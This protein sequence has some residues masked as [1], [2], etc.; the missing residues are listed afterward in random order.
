[1]LIKKATLCSNTRVIMRK[2]LAEERY[3]FY[4]VCGSDV[5]S[6]VN[7][8]V[9]ALVARILLMATLDNFRRASDDRSYHVGLFFWSYSWC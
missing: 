6:S 1:M 9:S 3:L 5:Q 2:T 7:S 4:H 8:T